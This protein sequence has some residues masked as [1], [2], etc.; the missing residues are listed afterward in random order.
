MVGRLPKVW[1]DL[2]SNLKCLTII[3]GHVQRK[4]Y[5]CDEG[6]QLCRHRIGYAPLNQSY[7][8]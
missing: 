1:R 6:S 2:S 3:I 8:Y 5:D 4:L 7:D